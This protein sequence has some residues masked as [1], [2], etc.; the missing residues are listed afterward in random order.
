MSGGPS[1]VLRRAVRATRQPPCQAAFALTRRRALRAKGRAG[2]GWLLVAITDV[3]Q[4]FFICLSSYSLWLL[5]GSPA[6]TMTMRGLCGGVLTAA[7]RLAIFL[8]LRR[9]NCET[10][11]LTQKI[12]YYQ[13]FDRYLG[14]RAV[15][16][17]G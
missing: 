6:L 13:V 9:G 15:P 11:R 8:P 10:A 2:I 5:G 17:A 1:G 3:I 12:Y 7:R 16:D 14:L 4:R